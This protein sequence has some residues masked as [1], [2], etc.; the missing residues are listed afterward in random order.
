MNF[1]K[2]ILSDD[3]DPP[4]SESDPDSPRDPN[5]ADDGWSFGGFVKS[6]STQSESVI[7]AYRRD[8]Q[9]FGSGLKKET[10]MLRESASRAVKDLP[11]SLDVVL[12]S[13]ASIITKESLGF[14]SDGEPET[15]GTNR[16]LNSGR[17]SR[18]EAQLSAIQSDLNSFCVEPGDAEDY[19]KW[20][21]GF[22][23]GDYED[24][25]DFLIGENGILE[26]VYR[27]AVPNA[28]DDET[29]WCRYFYRVEKLKQQESVR[30]S[31]VKRAI[32]NDD[33]ELSWDVEDD[34]NDSNGSGRASGLNVKGDNVASDGKSNSNVVELS[35]KNCVDEREAEVE[36]DERVKC[37]E[38]VK[39]GNDEK[40]VVEEKGERGNKS[41][42]SVVSNQPSKVVAA[43]EE[44][45]GWD[46]IGDVGSGDE[47]Q[48]TSAAASGGSPNKDDD[49]L[50]WDIEDDDEP[51]PVKA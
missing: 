15:P 44:D 42:A 36:R 45:L 33:E 3:P 9:E 14:S 29:F 37:E 47:K 34:D 28:V 27:K 40:V 30:A 22:E 12:K 46:E 7:E 5:D 51:V 11:A 24:E 13:T 6:F 35:E 16:S 48:N 39:D 32:W 4:N 21:L 41:D 1:F 31:I 23:L 25:I 2:S 26:G 17:Y 49:D 18:F 50:N 20:K 19:G 38:S 8:L 10:E 43:E